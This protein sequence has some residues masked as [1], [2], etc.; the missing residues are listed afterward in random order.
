MI[1]TIADP[2]ERLAAVIA[3][4]GRRHLARIFRWGRWEIATDGK[5]LVGRT[6]SGRYRRIPGSSTWNVAPAPIAVLIDGSS[7]ARTVPWGQAS[8]ADV[9]A[10]VN[11][12]E[13][14]GVETCQECG[15]PGSAL[16]PDD[17]FACHHC[18]RG[19]ATPADA[20]GTIN[21]ATFDRR[22]VALALELHGASSAPVRFR[23]SQSAG[24]F[25]PIRMAG[26]GWFAL[27]MGHLVLTSRREIGPELTLKWSQA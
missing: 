10:W 25:N 16:Y 7:E 17:D 15:D 12:A 13:Y 8:A 27:L 9:R 18:Y 14:T 6:S 5:L 24:R 19:K 22:R 26:P 23:R 4:D 21:G 2:L 11:G 20:P 1:P 3:L